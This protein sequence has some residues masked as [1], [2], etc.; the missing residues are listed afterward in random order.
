M[1]FNGAGQLYMQWLNR[2]QTL[3]VCAIYKTD[4]KKNVLMKSQILKNGRKISKCVKGSN[5]KINTGS[6]KEQRKEQ[7]L[8]WKPCSEMNW[9]KNFCH[10]YSSIYFSGTSTVTSTVRVDHGWIDDS[11]V[12]PKFST[13]GSY[14]LTLL[15][16]RG[17]RHLAKVDVHGAKGNVVFNLTF[18][19]S[20][21]F[22]LCVV[23]L[24]RNDA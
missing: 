3:S 23:C 2:L 4:G 11:Y 19:S 8:H 9:L 20:S 22:F 15:P 17:F 21:S 1:K 13:D 6:G 10:P 16:N 12:Y 7:Q 14:Y 24:V 5:N 18:S